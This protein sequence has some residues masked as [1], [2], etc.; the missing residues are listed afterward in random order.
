MQHISIS[1]YI[2]IL[3]SDSNMIAITC[4][5]RKFVEF[6]F[7]FIL[8]CC[9]NYV[10]HILLNGCVPIQKIFVLLYLIIKSSSVLVH[11]NKLYNT[12]L[13]LS[14]SAK[15]LIY[16]IFTLIIHLI[17]TLT[18]KMLIM[19]D[20]FLFYRDKIFKDLQIVMFTNL[21][22]DISFDNIDVIARCIQSQ[23]ITL[24]IM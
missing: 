4:I 20:I 13:F 5:Y 6:V 3:S 1:C 21:A 7:I 10:V 17:F 16:F 18:Y 2:L 12:K 23:C 24:T 11:N 14:Y 15:I 9:R 19:H 22:T 8:V